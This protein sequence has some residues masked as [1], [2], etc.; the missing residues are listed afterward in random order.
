VINGTIAAVTTV[1][2]VEDDRKVRTLIRWRLEVEGFR[3]ADVADGE[4]ALDALDHL[5]PDLLVL[6]L[7]LPGVPGLDVLTRVRS[8]SDLPVI[9]VSA[10]TGESDR[11]TGLDLGA[12]DYMVKPFSPDELAA[13]ARSLLRR[14]G[15]AQRIEA[16]PL[17]IDRSTR[18]VRLNGAE[19]ELSPKE[20]E[21][22]AFLAAAP[23][24][25]FTRDQLLQH[26]W[27]SN[28][29][30]QDPATVTQHVHRLRHKLGPAYI[31][32]VSRAGYRFGG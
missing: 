30:W 2:V 23:Q 24:R 8:R 15:G 20:F 11:I 22:L 25:A 32:T 4:T 5:S 19:V 29:H 27:H 6:D 3:V 26:V 12:D 14:A 10:R 1:L 7:S 16:G 21:L 13:R 9:I 28:S 31:R 17:T 18:A